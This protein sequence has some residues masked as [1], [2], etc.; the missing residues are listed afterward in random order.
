LIAFSLAI[1]AAFPFLRALDGEFLFDDPI[2][3]EKGPPSR[4]YRTLRE[5]HHD[6]RPMV[7]LID[8]WLWRLFARGEP[9]NATKTSIIAPRWPWHAVSILFHVGATLGVWSLAAL[10]LEPSRALMAAGI[11]AVHPLH[12]T[13]VAYVS[14]RSGV[15]SFFFSVLG[16]LHAAAGAWHWAA[17]P[18]CFYFALKSKQDGWLYLALLP[19]VLWKIGFSI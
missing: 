17:V 3:F 12:V 6:A 11:F 14:G 2:M 19:V 16:Y 18:V 10:I 15:Q 8:S 5:F 13:A 7:H 1:L 9:M 4:V